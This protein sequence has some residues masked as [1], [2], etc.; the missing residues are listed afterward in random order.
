MHWNDQFPD[1]F[2]SFL[3]GKK[4]GTAAAPLCF[5]CNQPG[6]FAASCS[7]RSPYPNRFH[8]FPP[9]FPRRSQEPSPMQ[10]SPS[11]VPLPIF[12]PKCKDCDSVASTTNMVNAQL[13][14]T[15]QPISVIGRA[16][17]DL[18][19]GEPALHSLSL[20]SFQ[21]T[22][23]SSQV[24]KILPHVSDKFNQLIVPLPS[25]P[26]TPVNVITLEQELTGYP[27]MNMVDYSLS[28][29]K[30]GF[31]K[32]YEGLNFPLIT[33]NL[34]SA[35]DNPE[36]V[37]AAII[38]EL[39]RGHTAGPFT[40]P[41]FE[42]FQCSPLGA[43]PKKDGTHC[44][45]I[46][47]SSPSGLPIND[48]ISK[49]DYSVTFSKFDDVVSLVKSLGKFALMAK[50]DIKHEFR[51]C[52]VSPIDWHLLGTHWEGFYFIELRLPFGLCSS[53]FILNSFADALEWILRNKYYP[54]ST[55]PLS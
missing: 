29:F 17:E 49:E 54:E 5:V 22:N 9:N 14:V 48:F 51:L 34:P 55:V 20:T 36:Q 46:D 43:V 47:L 3:R 13:A 15:Q 1:E 50:L 23:T 2:N 12:V 27:D 42:N 28:G 10:H 40:H 7:L 44:L 39:E 33:K 26:T 45:I 19:Q 41:P 31:R 18:T 16:V 35:R 4:Y 6:H 21:D 38:K 37:T 25:K 52:P 24:C 32:G 8:A 53:V 11:L 30:Q